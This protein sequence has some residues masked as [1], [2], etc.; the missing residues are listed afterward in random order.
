MWSL[1]GISLTLTD[2]FS[3]FSYPVKWLHSFALSLTG[4]LL[5]VL[6]ST[7]YF[8]VLT[9]LVGVVFVHPPVSLVTEEVFFYLLTAWITSF[10]LFERTLFFLLDNSLFIDL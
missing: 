10:V 7:S 8:I 9:I 6:D 4:H 3:F 5:Q 2:S 1:V